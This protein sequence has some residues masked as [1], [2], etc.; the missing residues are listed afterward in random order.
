MSHF[1]CLIAIPISTIFI[2]SKQ[3]IHLAN[4]KHWIFY[5]VV[6]H[7]RLSASFHIQAQV[8]F[9]ILEVK[10]ETSPGTKN[11]REY[12]NNSWKFTSLSLLCYSQLFLIGI[13]S[14]KYFNKWDNNYIFSDNNIYIW[15]NIASYCG[16]KYVSGIKLVST[17]EFNQSWRYYW[18]VFNYVNAYNKVFLFKLSRGN[19]LRWVGRIWYN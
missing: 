19:L 1:N 16:S 17:R 12:L 14:N 13:K 11:K 9:V 4:T 2:F 3:N 6:L 15:I 18:M 5:E 8:S 7:E 10:V